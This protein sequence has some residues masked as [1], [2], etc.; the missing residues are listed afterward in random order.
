MISRLQ[1]PPRASDPRNAKGRKV[2]AMTALYVV[3]L[4][5]VGVTAFAGAIRWYMAGVAHRPLWIGSGVLALIAD[6]CAAVG[7]ARH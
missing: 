7:L 2:L 4:G 3:A 6:T 5:M 1:P